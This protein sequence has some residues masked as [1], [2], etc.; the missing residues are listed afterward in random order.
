MVRW[1]VPARDMAVVLIVGLVSAVLALQ[2]W[3]SRLP[4]FDLIPYI[5]GAQ[6]LLSQGRLPDRGHV[7]SYQAYAPP[8]LAWVVAPGVAVFS[9]PRVFD[10]PGHLILHVGTL[11]GIFLLARSCFGVPCAL[12]SVL[13]YG[14]V[15]PDYSM[16]EG[17]E[18]LMNPPVYGAIKG[19]II[20]MTRHLASLYGRKGIRVNTVS[21]GGIFDSHEPQ[22]IER[23]N[24]KTMLG[25]M[26]KPEDIAGPIAFLLSDAASYI[27]GHNLMVD[28]GFVSM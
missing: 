22:F 2:G 16:Y 27:T 28:G 24:K 1:R 9:D 26:G 6:T 13:F 19:G 3:R 5:D 12:L 20:Q 18:H 17:Q 21:P 23:Y 25:R 10:A 8:G 14:V 4:D 15:G 11:A 7:T